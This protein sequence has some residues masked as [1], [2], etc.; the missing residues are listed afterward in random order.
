MAGSSE[1]PGA[2]AGHDIGA[3]SGGNTGVSGASGAEP[4]GTGTGTAATAAAATA[5][6]PTAAATATAT[7][8]AAT[9]AGPATAAVSTDDNATPADAATTRSIRLTPA[10]LTLGIASV[11]FLVLAY[12]FGYPAFASIGLA[13][14]VVL[15]FVVPLAARHAPVEIGREIYPVRVTRGEVAVGLLTVRNG[16]TAWGQRLSALERLGDRDIP[17]R[18]GQLP[19][20]GAVEIRY[21]LPTHRRGVIEVGPLRWDRTDP[22]GLIGR[23]SALPGTATLHVHPAVHRFPLGAAARNAHGDQARTDLAPE[24]SLTFHTLRDYVPGDDLRRIHWRASAHRDVLMVRQF[25]DVTPPRSTVLLITDAELY[26]SPD[27]F[28]EAVDVAASAA[29]GAI[30]SG[31]AVALWTTGGLRL[32]GNGGPEDA[33]LFLDRL[34]TVGWDATAR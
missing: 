7:A 13:G 6:A 9:G 14:L 20:R 25:I 16:S 22:L 8:T 1:F 34:S 30:R 28:E 26:A 33:M 17:V 18:I 4:S 11:A 3:R 32:T 19:P 23:R 10:G 2:G 5:A 24:G 15:A 27:D 12:A 31:E 21:P 29:V